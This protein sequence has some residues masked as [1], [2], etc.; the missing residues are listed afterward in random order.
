MENYAEFINGIFSLNTARFGKIAE[1]MIKKL[2]NMTNS[3]NLAYDLKDGDEKIEVK[4]SKAL[5]SCSN[6]INEKNAIS[7]IIG[8]NMDNR[9]ISFKQSQKEKFDCN[10]QQVKPK[11]FNSLYYGV[12]FSDKIMICRI[13]AYDIATDTEIKYSNHQHRNNTNEGQFHINNSTLDY[14]LDNYCIKWL[15]Y[16]ELY[17]LLKEI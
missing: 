2:F 13:S 16:E 8:A 7:S 17:K 15:S 6:T 11:E 4:F 5:K 10:I 14:H 12:F 3:D 9:K 1:L